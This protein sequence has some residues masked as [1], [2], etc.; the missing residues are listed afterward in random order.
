MSQQSQKPE[1][2]SGF[3]QIQALVIGHRYQPEIS[4][5]KNISRCQKSLFWF[6]R[7][8]GNYPEVFRGQIPRR[9]QILQGQDLERMTRKKKS[10]QIHIWLNFFFLSFPR[11]AIWTDRQQ[12]DVY[13]LPN[14]EARSYILFNSSSPLITA[15]V[16]GIVLV[17]SW[18]DVW[19]KKR[20]K[21]RKMRKLFY[22]PQFLLSF[23]HYGSGSLVGITDR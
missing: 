11:S 14:K 6:C 3:Q 9:S 20:G 16:G 12:I 1:Q 17:D 4:W 19:K 7:V 21:R 22:V 8:L 13:I 18:E 23:L 5:K 15:D 10:S 2:T